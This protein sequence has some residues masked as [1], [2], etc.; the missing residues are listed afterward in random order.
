MRGR[1]I[2]LFLLL[3]LIAAA[4]VFVW[5]QEPPP[6]LAEQPKTPV[7]RPPRPLQSDADGYYEPGYNFTVAGLRFTRLTLRP[8]AFVT[9]TRAGTRREFGCLEATIRADAVFVRC[10][11]SP[12][13][14]LVI[15]GKFPARFATSR[16]DT[17]VLSATVTVRSARGE[18]VYRA[19]DSFSW[20]PPE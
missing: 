20:H 5:I 2:A 8:E 10:D 19:R 7:A 15:D 1:R 3:G 12:V 11:L 6:P 13:G 18:T 16:M 9:F 4:A 14:T 17:P